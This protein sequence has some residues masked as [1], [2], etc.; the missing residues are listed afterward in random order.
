MGERVMTYLGTIEVTLGELFLVGADPR[1]VPILEQVHLTPGLGNGFYEVYGDIEYV[2]GYGYRITRM[3]IEF[4]SKEEMA[5]YQK[6]ESPE[7][8]MNLN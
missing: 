2:E 4:I 3:M 5:Y 7:I 8:V 6:K 1:H